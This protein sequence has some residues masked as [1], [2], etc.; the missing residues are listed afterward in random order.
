MLQK[1]MY[2]IYALSLNGFVRTVG[3]QTQNPA[4]RSVAGLLPCC[5]QADIKMRSHRLLRLDDNKF[6]ASCQ[7]NRLDAS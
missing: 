3:S 1:F 4:S 5:H 7:H 2:Y 6:A